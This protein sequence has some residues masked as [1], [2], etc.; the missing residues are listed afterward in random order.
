MNPIRHAVRVI[1][2]QEGKILCVRYNNPKMQG[3]LDFPGGKIEPGETELDACLREVKEEAGLDITPADLHY[4]GRIINQT[5]DLIYDLQT[6]TSTSISGTPHNSEGDQALW[7]PIDEIRQ[8]DKRLAITYMVDPELVSL[9][10]T[11]GFE[12]TF[13]SNASLHITSRQ[14]TKS[15]AP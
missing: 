15:P 1:A 14:I 5:P 2:F 3:F 10:K 11:P 6:Y 13:T 7:L 9:L 8:Y 4:V 12:I